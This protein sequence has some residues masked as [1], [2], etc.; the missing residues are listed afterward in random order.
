M[1]LSCKRPEEAATH[2][3]HEDE[4]AQGL[5]ASNVSFRFEVLDLLNDPVSIR[6]SNPILL[7][8]AFVR[9]DK[10]HALTGRRPAETKIQTMQSPDLAIADQ[11]N[12][13]HQPTSLGA[14]LFT[15]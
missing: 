11:D 7:G 13:L 9:F 3:G 2:H 14:V 10:P 8:D 4:F 12:R 1:C 6:Y 15:L 5:D